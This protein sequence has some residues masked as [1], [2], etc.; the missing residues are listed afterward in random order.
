MTNLNKASDQMLNELL[1]DDADL[2]EYGEWTDE[3]L[4]RATSN[5]RADGEEEYGQIKLRK[6]IDMETLCSSKGQILE[7][8]QNELDSAE[9]ARIATQ[10]AMDD[11]K[12]NQQN[13]TDQYINNELKTRIP[14]RDLFSQRLIDNTQDFD[15]QLGGM[16]H[17]IKTNGDDGTPLNGVPSSEAAGGIWKQIIYDGVGETPPLGSTV[18]IHYNAYFE[19]NDEPYDSTYI[20]RRPCEFQLGK[21]NVLPGLDLAVRTMQK[22]ERAKFIMS[23]DLLYGE[24]GCPP[25]IPPKAWSLFIVELISWIDSTIV[26]KLN[27]LKISDDEVTDDFNERIRIV[28]TLRDMGNDE[29]A[30][31]NLERAIR[32]YAKGKQF[33]IKTKTNDEHQSAQY[34]E[35]LLKLYLNSAQ[36]YLK[37]RNYERTIKNSNEALQLDSKSIKALFRISIAYRSM[38]QFDQARTYLNTAINIE[39]YNAEIIDEAQRLDR[40]IEQQKKNEQKLYYRMFN[41]Q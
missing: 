14:T 12:E 37:L 21:F 31:Q 13:D 35:L 10:M 17:L 19:L 39:P 8:D 6:P 32:Y 15:D 18:R 7:L 36:C 9:L 11:V 29:Y 34:K 28:Q 3:A 20:R 4:T 38:Q 23:S 41:K 27:K 5:K 25:R 16:Q 2:D 22:R 26:E 30:K 33:L 24:H 40:A 1:N